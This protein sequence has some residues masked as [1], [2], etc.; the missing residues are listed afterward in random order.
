MDAVHTLFIPNAKYS[1]LNEGWLF[2]S[3]TSCHVGSDTMS[4]NQLNQKLK[5]MVE[6]PIYSAIWP[7][8][9]LL[10]FAYRVFMVIH[11]KFKLFSSWLLGVL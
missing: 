1:T 4:R 2:E 9:N 10:Y 5:L 6:V 8:D 11:S 7:P 3:V